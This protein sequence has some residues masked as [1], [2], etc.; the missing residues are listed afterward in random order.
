[1]Q[2]A[3]GGGEAAARRIALVEDEPMQRFMLSTLLASAGF[4]A[5]TFVDGGA[6]LRSPRLRE[7]DLILLDWE[8]PAQSGLQVLRAL[9]EDGV[10][11]P[12]VFL[13]A[14]EDE[15]RVVEALDIG[16][17]DYILKPPRASE[18]AARIRA[19]MR[20]AS[21][22]GAATPA[23]ATELDCPPYRFDLVNR[24]LR[25]AGKPVATTTREFELARH[26]FAHPG[27]TIS[28]HSLLVRVWRTSPNVS[29]R[30]IDTFVSR[31]RKRIGLDGS[32][33]WKLE[34]LYQQGYRLVA[35]ETQSPA[36][37]PRLEP[38]PG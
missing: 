34:A 32:H 10:A 1:M 13:T 25:I 20:R 9:R 17:D 8:L 7:F 12:V 4:E 24:Q 29:T 5:S 21:G 3:P 6:L 30:S 27:Q 35:V 22:A 14:S 18:L 23:D 15:R 11:S 36:P 19:V 28:R 38:V 2:T 31:L 33:G 26:F 37:A 16:A